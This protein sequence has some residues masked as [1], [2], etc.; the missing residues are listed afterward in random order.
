MLRKNPYR[1]N[2]KIVSDWIFFF[3][4][5]VLHEASYHPIN[6]VVSL[7]NTE[8]I[9]TTNYWQVREEKERGAKML[10]GEIVYNDY[11]RL[12]YGETIL[13]KVVRN[14][15]DVPCLYKFLTC[16]SLFVFVLYK[17]RALLLKPFS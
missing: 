8:G 9:S 3:D 14:V 7:F 11:A 1:E 6:T 2:Y 13:E 4:E 17:I 16:L 15:E 10:L 12:S 5:L